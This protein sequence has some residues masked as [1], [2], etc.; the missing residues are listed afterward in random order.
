MNVALCTKE[1]AQRH[2]HTQVT[3]LARWR[4]VACEA[5]VTN[6]APAAAIHL[7]AQVPEVMNS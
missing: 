1:C 4:Y 2:V 6:R 7:L 5:C 3:A